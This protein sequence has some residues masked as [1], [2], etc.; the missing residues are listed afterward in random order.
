MPSL[1]DEWLTR[2]EIEGRNLERKRRWFSGKDRVKEKKTVHCKDDIEHEKVEDV[3]VKQREN[4]SDNESDLFLGEENQLT[5]EEE[6][7][8]K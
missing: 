1:H 6:P 3:E 2:K 8:T 7:T 4:I 5:L